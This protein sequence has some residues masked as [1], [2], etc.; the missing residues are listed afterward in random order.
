MMRR[1]Y[2]CWYLP[3]HSRLRRQLSGQVG[4]DIAAPVEAV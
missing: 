4:V 3:E 1:A 2:Q